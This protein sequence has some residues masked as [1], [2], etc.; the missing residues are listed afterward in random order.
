MELSIIIPAY[1][2][3]K[4]IKNTLKT[5]NDY[6]KK[7]T[8]KYEFIIVS[9]G[10]DKTAKIVK[11]FSEKNKK[12]KLLEYP[13]RLGK[14]GAIKEGFKQAQGE[15]IGF[16]DADGAIS[17]EEFYKLVKQISTNT[18]V[19]IGSRKMKESKIIKHQTSDR[20]IISK[21]FNIL[22]NTLFRLKITDT[23]CGSKIFKKEVI[24]TILPK[25]KT[26]GFEI[27]IEILH[28]IKINH[29]T[30]KEIPIT[31]EHKEEAT[32][33]FKFIPEMFFGLIKIL[34]NS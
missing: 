12:I 33:N 11:E 26:K 31:W 22:V 6:I 29:Y 28:Q 2:E 9:D 1:N 16:T 32:F 20:E 19:V 10:Q 24:D 13:N 23:Q 18:D 8:E 30:I 27:D 4:R 3:E 34:I 5:Y 21:V 14:G 17:P 7:K 15:I 25:I